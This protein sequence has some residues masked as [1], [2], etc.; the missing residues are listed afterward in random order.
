M[1]DMDKETKLS[2]QGTMMDDFLLQADIDLSF[3]MTG[4]KTHSLKE[5]CTDKNPWMGWSLA[6]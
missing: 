3:H 1:E 4:G 5:G 6:R 2:A